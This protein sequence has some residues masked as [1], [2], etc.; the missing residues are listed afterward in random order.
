VQPGITGWAQVNQGHVTDLEHVLG[1]LH[2]DFY[3]IKNFSIWLD[4][5]IVL[6]TIRTMLTGFGAR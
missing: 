5:M 6:K 1:K 2:Y 4:I 3:Y